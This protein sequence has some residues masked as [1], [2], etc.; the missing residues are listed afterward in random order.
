MSPLLVAAL[1]LAATTAARASEAIATRAGCSA[2]HAVDKK[3]LGPSYKEIAARYKGRADAVALLSGRVRK[4]ST[5]E[6]GKVPMPATDASR[7]SDADLNTV[8]TWLLKTGG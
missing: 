4:G 6:W 5:G 2:C 7:L 3:L 8:V 1:M